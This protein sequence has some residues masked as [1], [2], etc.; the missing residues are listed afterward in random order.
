MSVTICTRVEVGLGEPFL[1]QTNGTNL[2]IIGSF[3]KSAYL[4]SPLRFRY[5]AESLEEARKYAE[6]DPFVKQGARRME[7]HE[8]GMVDGPLNG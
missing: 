4:Q 8:W 7:I 3:I 6:A 2:A 1:V 5:L